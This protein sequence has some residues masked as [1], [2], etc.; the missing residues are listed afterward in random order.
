MDDREKEIRDCNYRDSK[1]EGDWFPASI[2]YL[3]NLLDAERERSKALEVLA[4]SS[5]DKR[6]D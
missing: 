3:L 1:K 4:K 5:T 6:K 2:A